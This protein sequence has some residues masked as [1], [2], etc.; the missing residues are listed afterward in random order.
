MSLLRERE[1]KQISFLHGEVLT[2]PINRI[3]PSLHQLISDSLL[4]CTS[5]VLGMA[6]FGWRLGSKVQRGWS[7]LRGFSSVAI[8]SYLEVP[9]LPICCVP[10]CASKI[11]KCLLLVCGCVTN[12]FN[13][14]SV[15]LSLID[16]A[17]QNVGFI[18]LG[19]MGSHMA[20][21]LITA[22]FKVTVHDTYVITDVLCFSHPS[23]F[24]LQSCR[25]HHVS[26]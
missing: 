16:G 3:F 17:F 7:G 4:H 18:G 8:P 12:V 13:F 26:A 5:R 10:L 23:L 9:K 15:D 6:G 2:V 24:A 21:N 20:R 1:L 11:Q 19:N 22:G 14:C 25:N